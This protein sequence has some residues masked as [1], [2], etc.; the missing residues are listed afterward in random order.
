M[1]TDTELV[2][3]GNDEGIRRAAQLVANGHV[4]GIF[5]DG[6]DTMWIDGRQSQAAAKI[7]SIK[8]EARVGKPLSA[9]IET[10]ALV[11]LI[12]LD[13]I[14]PSLR[15]IFGNAENLAA[16]IGALAPLRLPVRAE[17]AR[18]LPSY[19]VSLSDDGTYWLQDF[20]PS[21][22]PATSQLVHELS[23]AGISLPAA[24]SMNI[25]G[26][27]EIANQEEAMAFS[28]RHGIPMLLHDPHPN[29]HIRGS[30]PILGV[31]PESVVLLREGHYPA[32]LL[33]HLLEYDEIDV[34]QAKPARYPISPQIR[35]RFADTDL[36]GASLRKALLDYIHG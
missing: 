13:L 33:G 19:M 25:S 29:P 3:F 7:Q 36:R 31:G 28:R 2:D 4:I 16:R 12:D 21:G 11:P 6:V 15:D 1:A 18:E 35:E 26:T 22:H 9:I 30:F 10:D 34:S 24:T 17:A 20:I 8:G 27:P 23:L 14:P 32:Q 5:I